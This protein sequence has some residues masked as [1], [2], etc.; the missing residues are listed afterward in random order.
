MTSVKVKFRLSDN[1]GEQG[2]IYYQIIHKRV[3]RQITSGLRVFLRE[4]NENTESPDIFDNVST[5]GRADYLL[6][7][8][9][10][11]DWDVK[12]LNAVI[13]MFEKEGGEYSADDIVSFFKERSGDYSF[14]NFT[15]SMVVSLRK[16]GKVRTSEAYASALK[17]FMVFRD[18]KDLV[19][20]EVT[21]ELMQKYEAFLRSRGVVKNS[22]SF[23]MRIL[24]AI[25]NRAVDLGLVEQAN[26]FRRVYTGVDKTVKRAIPLQAV[27]QIKNLDLSG[28]TRLE[29]ARDMFLFSFYTRG[30]SFVD[31]AYLK[32]KDLQKDVLIYVRRK[33]GQRLIIKWEQCMQDIVDKYAA[34]CRYNYML[35]VLQSSCADMV[36]YRNVL[37]CV[38]RDLKKLSVMVGLSVPLTM[39]VAR[40][41]W[42]SIARSRNIP[43]A[44]ISEGLGHDSETTTQIYLSSIDVGVVDKANSLILRLL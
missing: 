40:H 32:K 11:L 13:A 20:G 8:K 18:N 22:S 25:Y 7:V 21:S 15:K 44:V 35:P 43:L 38:N 5:D 17:S 12:R 28:N 23:Y 6:S 34:F 4:W 30:M 10:R 3:V 2:L 1:D 36:Y 41:S 14:F 31:M 33:T 29:F 24:R 9:A 37:R 16:S 42:A 27:R 39:Y 26:P 19:W